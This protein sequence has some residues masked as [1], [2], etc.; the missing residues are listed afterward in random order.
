M[1][2]LLAI[3]FAFTIAVEALPGMSPA[4]TPSTSTNLEQRYGIG[5]RLNVGAGRLQAVQRLTITNRARHA[6][7]Y[8]NL[9]VLPRAF[10]YFSFTGS[11]TVA[12]EAVST[13]WTTGTNL[14]VPLGRWVG[15]GQTVTIRIPFRLV[16]GSSGGAFTA[17]LSRDR[18]VISFGQWFPI[19][20]REHDSYGVGDP[21]VTRTAERIRLDLTTTG[22]LPRNAVACPGLR[23]APATSGRR[24]V[25]NNTKVRD[26]SFVV[27]P[28]FRLTTRKVDGIVLRVYTETVSGAVTADKARAAMA[29][30][31]DLYGMYPWPDL[32]LAEVGADG[33]FSME[34][35]RAIHLTRS[36]VRDSYIINHEVAHQWFYAQLGNDQMREPWLDEGFADF[37]ARLLMR[38]GENQCSS[39]EV[40]SPVFAWPAGR[41][42]GGDWQSCQ[43]Y[44]HT[45][46]YKGT[47]FLNAV[48]STMGRRA[49][50]AAVRAYIA[51]HR[52]GLTTTRGLL[53]YLQSRT[54]ANLLPL[55]RRYLDAYDS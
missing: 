11:V 8:V 23:S 15:T 36:K 49:F 2:G 37:T 16:V 54:D 28:R 18:G 39:R 14:R 48:R 6:I 19:V 42:S 26:F 45:V 52:Y 27:N 21:Q 13:R 43:G 12:G 7:N 55:Y 29:V 33:G 5:A 51:D 1:A 10:G 35:P 20:S 25:C 31:N 4:R 9:S 30:L 22:S 32:V 34:Y 41:T 46:F 24:W 17:R 38:I 44:L 47:E 53:D 50:F 3:A 40:D